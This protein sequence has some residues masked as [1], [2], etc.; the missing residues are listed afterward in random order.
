MGK[1]APEPDFS[2]DAKLTASTDLTHCI[3]HHA[4]HRC[5]LRVRERLQ[6]YR[7]KSRQHAPFGLGHRRLPLDPSG[8]LE[9]DVVCPYIAAY[10]ARLAQK[11]DNI[12]HLHHQ[13]LLRR[14]RSR[15]LGSV[16]AVAS[17]LG[18]SPGGALYPSP[19]REFVQYLCCSILWGHGYCFGHVAL[20]NIS[21]PRQSQH[22]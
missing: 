13:L 4:E 16:L 21:Q 1:P 2:V 18:A 5:S 17:A 19:L 10:F 11:M 8:L 14:Q 15:P 6:H 12:R 3:L 7:T 9:Q 22:S 20:D